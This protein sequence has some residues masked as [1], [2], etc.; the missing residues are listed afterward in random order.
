V[1]PAASVEEPSAFDIEGEQ[2]TIPVRVRS[3]AM[4]AAQFLVDADAAQRLI[5]YSGLRIARPIAGKAM[6]ALSGVAYADN[7]LGPYH[8]F[9]VAFVVEPHDAAPGA[10]PS[11]QRPTTLIHRLPVNQAFTCAAGKGIWGFPKW[12]CDIEYVDRG[13]RVECVVSDQ[14]DL[15][16][17]L[18]VARGLVPLPAAETEMQAY[19]WDDGVLRRTP[20]TTRNQLARARP[21]GAR[22]QLGPNHPM[23]DELRQLGLPKAALMSTSVGVM[24][25]TFGAPEVVELGR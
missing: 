2:I 4:V 24:S 23:A 6:L 11:W 13:G 21:R 5:D 25:A 15:A 8:E 16:V 14:G 3:A 12:V 7:D 19:S 17:G 10:K 22:L 9:A 20:W 18:E 1:T